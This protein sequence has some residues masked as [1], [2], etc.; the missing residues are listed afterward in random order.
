M[1]NFFVWSC[2]GKGFAAGLC[3]LTVFVHLAP[4]NLKLGVCIIKFKD[5]FS[6]HFEPLIG[7]NHKNNIKFSFLTCGG[8]WMNNLTFFLIN[9]EL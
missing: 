7:F 8:V 5:N 2:I 9:L 4:S 1:V 6:K 3:L